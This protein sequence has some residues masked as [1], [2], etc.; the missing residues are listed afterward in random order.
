MG[1]I[2]LATAAGAR[3]PPLGNI[4]KISS[5]WRHKAARITVID[6]AC[7]VLSRLRQYWHERKVIS[8]M[9]RNCLGHHLHIALQTVKSDAHFVEALP[10]KIFNRW[11]MVQKAIESVLNHHAFAAH[12]WLDELTT[13]SNHTTEALAA[14]EGK[15]APERSIRITLSLAFLSPALAQAAI[16][17]RLPEASGSSA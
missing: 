14:R 17:G 6:A 10:Y 13:N 12:R 5:R 9:E 7:L 1:A 3:R 11:D 2:A 15:T 4:P 16:D 8:G